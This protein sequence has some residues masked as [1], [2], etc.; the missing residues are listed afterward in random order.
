MAPTTRRAKAKRIPSH[1][2]EDNGTD[3]SLLVTPIQIEQA[4]HLKLWKKWVAV[5]SNFSLQKLVPASKPL[6]SEPTR[7]TDI[8]SSA[9]LPN[10]KWVCQSVKEKPGDKL[11]RQYLEDTSYVKRDKVYWLLMLD[12]ELAAS[13][14]RKA[15][16]RGWVIEKGDQTTLQPHDQAQAEKFGDAF[17]RLLDR[18]PLTLDT[19]QKNNRTMHLLSSIAIVTASSG[20][21]SITQS[22]LSQTFT[23]EVWKGGGLDASPWAVT[24]R[25]GAYHAAYL[26]FGEDGHQH[27]S[28]ENRR[29]RLEPG[30]VA[31]NRA[32]PAL[33]DTASALLPA[34]ENAPTPA[35]S[36]AA[37]HQRAIDLLRH[38]QYTMCGAV[39]SPEQVSRQA[40]SIVS[41]YLKSEKVSKRT[42]SSVYGG[43]KLF[44]T[45]LGET[46]V[47]LTL[48]DP[49]KR[50]IQHDAGVKQSQKL[51]FPYIRVA[52]LS[53]ARV[54]TVLERMYEEF[55]GGA[56]LLDMWQAGTLRADEVNNT[57]ADRP[58]VHV[59]DHS[60]TER[61]A[62]VHVCQK[63]RELTFC[64]KLVFTA[65]GSLRVCLGCDARG[66]D[67][68][69][70]APSLRPPK[71]PK[72]P[73]AGATFETKVLKTLYTERSA[74]LEDRKAT[75]KHVTSKYLK[76]DGLIDA[77][78]QNKLRAERII[79]RT[80]TRPNPFTASPDAADI[81]HVDDSG[82]T[83]IHHRDN[84]AATSY[85]A[86]TGLY[87]W[88]KGVLSAVK[89]SIATHD[90]ED[91]AAAD[92]IL[93]N[94]SN[95]LDHLWAIRCKYP[96]GKKE[97]LAIQMDQH[98]YIRRRGEWRQ[99][100]LDQ[101]G[102][103]VDGY[104]PYVSI[105]RP[106]WTKKDRGR[107]LGLITQMQ[108]R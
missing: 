101:S 55:L 13:K 106:L 28:K 22:E 75:A 36:E 103:H 102:H 20:R 61:R 80:S 33:P 51:E 100:L 87:T 91:N 18:I 30:Q 97:R 54:A 34:V 77:Y 10:R 62:N 21:N 44:K 50:D 107:I 24:W 60:E 79:D 72:P 93:E 23:Q 96:H 11:P 56:N 40:H 43:L 58:F 7:I 89:D 65:D 38:V 73:K 76:K 78:F 42:W 8:L 94:V 98:E 74:S 67:A 32:V 81:L 49:V 2:S 95:R 19:R 46:A 57:P 1:S 85:Y 83:T 6:G 17:C 88:P 53:T 12:N 9:P 3:A 86:N 68:S 59:C 99:S 14:K 31:E 69:F 48:T 25:A 29:L 105:S 104:I 70:K 82:K 45:A 4:P 47:Y 16:D 66:R 84:I 37:S 63:C 39:G 71:P 27:V 90:L 41:L 35:P 92:D 5:R 52:G 108:D 64:D 15:W 26:S